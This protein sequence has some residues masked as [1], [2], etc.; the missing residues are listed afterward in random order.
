MKKQ[1]TLINELGNRYGLLTVIGMIKD[2]DNKTVW[3]CQC[4]CGNTKIVKGKDL[5]RGNN[6]TCGRGCKLK[7]TRNGTFKD[8]TGQKFDHLTV[9]SFKEINDK[10]QS[11]WHCKC[12]C[13]KECDIIG[14]RMVEGIIKSCGCLK[15]ANEEIIEQYLIQKHI[16]YKREQMFSDLLSIKKYPLRYDFGIYNINSQLIGLIEFQG[17]QHFKTV[18][19]F[20]GEK[21]YKKRQ[22][23][24]ELK[25]NYAKEHNIP[26]LYLIKEDNLKEKI[27]IF[28][29]T[30]LQ[31]GDI[32]YA[33]NLL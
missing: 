6:T 25:Y 18:Q 32:K 27:D 8:L 2:A 30:I 24:D 21:D 3:L 33:S 16:L 15:S 29:N 11:V 20:D 28:L 19:Y 5:R 7:Y 13:G 17:D 31:E 26:I 10:H 14:C 12:D 4:D 9:L 23:H 22:F 1:S